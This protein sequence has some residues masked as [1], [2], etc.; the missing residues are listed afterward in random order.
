LATV[1]KGKPKAPSGAVFP[2]PGLDFDEAMARLVRVP[3][4]KTGKKAK[5][6]AGAK[7]RKKSGA[8]KKS[9][10]ASR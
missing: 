9:P 2:D 3:P 6:S 1:P 7:A 4:P 8:A 5:K 10:S